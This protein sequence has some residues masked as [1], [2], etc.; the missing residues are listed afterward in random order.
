MVGRTNIQ[1]GALWRFS[2]PYMADYKVGLVE[3]PDVPLSTAVAAS[4]A[5]PPV[6]S[7]VELNVKKYT[8]LAD[9][10]NTLNR[11]PFT[12]KAVLSDG[13]VYD[14]MG[15]ETVWKRCRTVLVS[16]A[17]AALPAEESPASDW[18]RHSI[19]VLNVIDNQVRSLRKRELIAAFEE[20]KEHTGAYWSMRSDPA[21][22]SAKDL[23]TQLGG[24]DAARAA[25]LAATPTRL[26]AL[27]NAWQEGLINLG[28]VLAAVAVASHVP[29]PIP[30]APLKWPFGN[31]L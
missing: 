10:R 31:R 12:E 9:A 25:A 20:D 15:M 4:S 21:K 23:V 6:L 29:S 16:D 2:R 18:A 17:G 28:Y 3:K 24:F 27:D 30:N 13:G 8:F 7:P 1:S 11:P 22:Y 5:F 26:K 14:N 19:R